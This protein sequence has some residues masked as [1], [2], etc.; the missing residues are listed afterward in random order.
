[1]ISLYGLPFSLLPLRFWRKVHAAPNGCWVW[2]GAQTNRGYGTA[3]MPHHNPQRASA[4]RL[5]YEIW[6]DTIP[7]SLEI[8]HL[9]RNK[10]CVNPAHLEAVSHR[11]NVHRGDMTKLRVTHCPMGHEY[12]GANLY[13]RPD[14]G[15]RDCKRCQRKRNRRWEARQKAHL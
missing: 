4:H 14:N 8:D 13:I 12:A 1:M 10:A 3:W 11:T 7:A 6:A 9:C 2:I 5:T 15:N